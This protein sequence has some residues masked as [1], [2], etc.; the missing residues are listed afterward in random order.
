M[1]KAALFSGGKDSIYAALLEWP[2]DIFVTFVYQFPRPSPHLLNIHKL[3]ELANAAGIPV[4]ILKVDKGREFQ[5]EADFLRKLGVDVVVAGDQAV[6]DHLKYME[7]LAH[8]AGASLREP[9]WGQD[10][11]EILAREAEELDFVVIGASHLDLV[12]DYVGSRNVGRFLE[13]ARSL[14]VDPIGE[15]GEYHTLV[16]EIKRLAASIPF[17]CLDVRKYVDYYIA[18]VS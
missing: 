1:L 18:L 2:V 7:R 15:R 16:V 5:Q 6:E 12:C 10:P 3:I 9:L 8:E 17:R 11:A 4:A 13:K 14:G